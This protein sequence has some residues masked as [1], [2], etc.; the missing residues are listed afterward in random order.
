MNLTWKITSQKAIVGGIN[1]SPEHQ[2]H[3]DGKLMISVPN[4]K[5]KESHI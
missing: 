4:F 3:V 5:Y 1:R 2:K